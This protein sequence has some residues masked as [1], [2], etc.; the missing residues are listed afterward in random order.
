MS[1]PGR[2]AIV[3]LM[4]AASL[5]SGC[6]PRRRVVV[7]TGTTLGLK[8][9]PGDGQSRPP[10]VTLGYKRA[11]LAL[12]PTRGQ[13]ATSGAP[14]CLNPGAGA[15][16]AKC[17]DAFSTLTAFDFRTRWFG[18]TQLSSFVSTGFAAREI[19][20]EEAA[21]AG[22]AGAPEGGGNAFTTEFEKVFH[23]A[24]VGPATP[25]DLNRKLTLQGVR[26]T[27][28]RE[29]ARRVL[30]RAGFAVRPA[31]DP[32]QE[33]QERIAQARGDDLE[34]LEAAVAALGL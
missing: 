21:A 22:K 10:Q 14:E 12:V 9:T 4:L 31:D 32:R 23:E 16:P 6:D 24:T 25:A 20:V 26:R 28:S 30:E 3:G 34:R 17:T 13:A 29:D 19:Q 18:A 15:A 27:L 7:A 1:T 2:L 5:A 11:E 8:A 33:L